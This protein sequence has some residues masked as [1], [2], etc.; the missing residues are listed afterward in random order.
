M[1]PR[2][3]S[4]PLLNS[5]ALNSRAPGSKEQNCSRKNDDGAFWNGLVG[6][7]SPAAAPTTPAGSASRRQIL[8]R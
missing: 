1:P 2:R 6:S 7:L 8:A 3:H 4:E 5:Q